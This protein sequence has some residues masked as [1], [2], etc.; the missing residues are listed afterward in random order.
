MKIVGMSLEEF[1][2]YH[3]VNWAPPTAG[4]IVMH[5]QNES[6][7]TT[8]MKFVRSMLFGYLR[9]DWQGY[10]GN[11]EIERSD[12][13]RYR[14][15][16]NE[17]NSWIVVDGETMHA[18]PADLWWNGLERDTYEKIFALGLEDLQGVKILGNDEVRSRFFSVEGGERLG[19]V[20]RQLNTSMTDLLVGST[21][22]KK[23]IN[24]L[25]GEQGEFDQKIKEMARHEVE[26]ASLQE[27]EKNTYDEEKTVRVDL[28]AVKQRLEEV[29][30]SLTAW[31]VYRRGQE[32]MEHIQRLA[33]VAQFPADGK[34][35]WGELEGKIKQV[36]EQIGQFRHE[37]DKIVPESLELLKRWTACGDE[38]EELFAKVP[39]WAQWEENIAKHA[40]R[41]AE[42]DA[43]QADLC[44]TLDC[45]NYQAV[46]SAVVD[47]KTGF[48][49]ATK[50]GLLKQEKIRW[51]AAKPKRALQDE[52]AWVPAPRI[53]N[54]E[55]W[56]QLEGNVRH[57]QQAL[58]ERQQVAEQISWLKA[59][60][61][62]VS[63]TT[64]WVAVIFAVLAMA[65]LGGASLIPLS[66][67]AVYSG[68]G[69]CG[70][71]A[72]FFLFRYA[73]NKNRVPNRL[74]GLEK[75]Q[76]DLSECL[77]A[78]D[79]E[80][81]LGIPSD[82]EELAKMEEKMEA[83]RQEFFHWQE[84]EHRRKW[85]EQ[86][87]ELFQ[88]SLKNWADEGT[89]WD[90]KINGQ[91]SAWQEWA[92]T[93]QVVGPTYENIAAAKHQWELWQ[94][95]NTERTQWENGRDE[96]LFKTRQ[97]RNQTEEIFSKLAVQGR[98]TPAEVERQYHILQDMRIRAEVAKEKEK[99]RN[100]L[101]EQ[102]GRWE[103]EKNAQEQQRDELFKEAGVMTTGEFRAK[104]LRYEQYKQYR[105]IYNQSEDHLRLL[106]KGAKNAT[107][108]KKLLQSGTTDVWNREKEY[109]E[110]QAEELDNK[111][112][113]IAEQ[114]GSVVERLRQLAG[115]EAFTKLL[116]K[117]QN[118]NTVLQHT[119]DE[120]LAQAF[121]QLMM[122]EAQHFYEKERQ[123]LV[124]RQASEYVQI[125]TKGRYTLQAS[126]DGRDLYAVD[127][128]QNRIK[129]GQWSSGLGDQ[130][131]LAIRISL[132]IAFS[133]QIEPL[134]LI[135]DDLLV[136]FDEQR[137]R[138]A[139]QFLGE[140]GKK[141][142]IFLFT[143][144]E[145]TK[146]LAKLTRDEQDLPI[147]IFEISQGSVA[148]A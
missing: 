43:R 7:K 90:S 74:A 124:I 5:G 18:E 42:W 46:P 133:Q 102:S 140:L 33:D 51:E 137:Q 65:L 24:L 116:Q 77:A 30:L 48:G 143:C 16:R 52:S 98:L 131:Y 117:K 13:R 139:L 123:P 44:Q 69:G 61:T 67:L 81:Q 97:Y 107:N 114:R 83:I 113:L 1:G 53:K 21:Q 39:E 108:L 134:P 86:Q 121:T 125:M 138:E 34:Q 105:E 68:A 45:W 104:S 64:Q 12:G 122:Q 73:Q 57:L 10:F 56:Q 128:M 87:D 115:S 144:Q 145:Q 80:V 66:V 100:Q 106:A 49:L 92:R 9:G 32:A 82:K 148:K 2:I 146:Q 20:R 91:L 3:Q 94:Q 31:D 8:L 93:N 14:I 103:Q 38:L 11:M 63:H 127:V 19:L 40:A 135:L 23:K 101:S 35:R 129:E 41:E 29:S 109:Y 118:S 62:E 27:Q 58:I 84:L 76:A 132:A 26:F 130:I 96:E 79:G 99:Q 147:H 22:G 60:P 25:M 126:M 110:R 142:Q 95:F 36:D 75:R 119:I 59:N 111:L 88:D 71:L 6:G 54:Q 47:W 141:E 136:R 37:K 120:W 85:E 17:K 4:L 50:L 78:L 15:Y 55:E 70:V 89:E 72:V 112:A 28:L